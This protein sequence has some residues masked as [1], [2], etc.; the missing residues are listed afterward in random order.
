[1]KGVL[2]FIIDILQLLC[3]EGYCYYHDLMK[4]ALYP[5]TNHPNQFPD[6]FGY[7]TKVQTLSF[8]NGIV[9][10]VYLGAWR[11]SDYG[12]LKVSGLDKYLTSLFNDC[13]MRL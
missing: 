1:M 10:S 5:E 7:G 11:V 12:V 6:N 2:D 4:L 13:N 3:S 8:P 9:G